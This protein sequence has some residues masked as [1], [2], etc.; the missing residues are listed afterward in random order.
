MRKPEE[1]KATH[2]VVAKDL[3][4]LKEGELLVKDGEYYSTLDESVILKSNTLTGRI[5]K[6][7]Q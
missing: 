2:V 5:I 3:E 6:K 4:I 7:I 1:S